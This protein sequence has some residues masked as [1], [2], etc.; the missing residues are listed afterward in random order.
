LIERQADPALYARAVELLQAM[1]APHAFIADNGPAAPT[2]MG[3]ARR[4][5][6]VGISGEFGGGGT[7][8]PSSMAFTEACLDRLLVKTGVLNAPV[9]SRKPLPE[10]QETQFLSLARHSQGIYAPHRG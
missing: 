1:G 3:A 7:V 2:S 10:L 6:I 5:G 4:A 8:T 9:L